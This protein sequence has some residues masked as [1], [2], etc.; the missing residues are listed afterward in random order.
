MTTLAHRGLAPLRRTL[1]NGATVIAQN[2]TTHRAVTIHASVA[3]GSGHDADDALGTA[4]FVAKVIDRGTETHSADILAEAFDNRGVSLSV[5]VSRHLMTFSCT[6][7]SEDIEAVLGLVAEVMAQPAF[8]P[9]QVELRRSSIVT[10][11]R[12]DED[13]PA[14]VA[15]EA[16]MAMLYPGGHPYGRRAKGTGASVPSITR[17]ALVA[18]HR[19]H[20]G[21]QSLRVVIVGHVKADEAVALADAAFGGW[22]QP[23]GAPLAPPPAPRGQVRT[24]QTIAMPGKVQSDIAYGFTSVTRPDPRYYALT[25]MNTVLGQ[26]AMGGRLGDSIRERQG[27][28]YYVFSGFDAN[29]AEGPLMVQAGVNPANVERAIAS[30]D[31]ELTRMSSEGVTASELADAKHYM[32]GSMPRVLETNSGIAG[33]LHSADFFGLGLDFDQRLPGLLDAVTLD[34]VH[35]VARTFLVPD[36]AAIVVAGPPAGAGEPHR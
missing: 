36:R 21:G 34:E 10:S 9:D 8:A 2:T 31:E 20:L 26:Y 30:I 13:N 23:G 3:A 1:A 14:A 32:I 25:L 5:G 15:A 12:Q 24:R 29:V 35:D 19:A 17:D 22:S 18:F 4:H 7:L 27:M 28:A 11:I 33:F 6:C 16:L